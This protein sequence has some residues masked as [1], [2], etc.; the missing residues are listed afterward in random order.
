M[1]D[2]R[3]LAL[4]MRRDII[5]MA[6]NAGKKG[7]HIGGGMSAVDI[8][9]VLYGGVMHYDVNDPRAESRDRFIM[10]KAHSAIAMYAA[11]HQVGFLNDSEISNAMQG[12]ALLYKHPRMNIEK[13]IEFSGGSLGQGLPLGAGMAFAMKRKKI[14]SKVYVLVGDGECDEGSIWEA[15]SSIVNF[16]LDNVITIIDCNNLQN[17]GRPADVMNI[18]DMRLRWESMG[19]D[20]IEI[21]G[22]D[23]E[24]IEEALTRKT[25]RPKAIIANTIKGK[26]VPFAEDRVE[27]H[28]GYIDDEL[29]KQALEAIDAANK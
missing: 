2:Y 9:A 18:G 25:I 14:E 10:S 11:L 27:W 5:N 19:Y 4:E 28:I 15:A 29:Y 17:D 13:G 24:Q 3:N 22:H 6:H 26:G 1:K 21:D 23:Y 7:A 20:V 8:L 16:G 12:D